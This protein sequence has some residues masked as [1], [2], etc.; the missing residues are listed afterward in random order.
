MPLSWGLSGDFLM[1]RVELGVF[2][3]KTTDVKGHFHHTIS[4]VHA[5]NI[6]YNCWCWHWSPGWGLPGFSAVSYFCLFLYIALQKEV[7]IHSPHLMVGELHFTSLRRGNIYINYLKF[8]HERFFSSPPFIYLFDHVNGCVFP[9]FYSDLN[10]FGYLAAISLTLAGR[11]SFL[12]LLTMNN[13][14]M[15]LSFLIGSREIVE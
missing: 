10:I 14:S 12:V 13:S 11:N 5:V 1:F 9:C 15:F 2:G 8:L 7:G 6:S 3:K 4:R